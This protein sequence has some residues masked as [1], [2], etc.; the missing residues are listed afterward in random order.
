MDLDEFLQNQIRSG[1]GQ[2]LVWNEVV[3]ILHE[4]AAMLMKLV[5]NFKQIRV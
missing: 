5:H 1:S 4:H 3:I 2:A